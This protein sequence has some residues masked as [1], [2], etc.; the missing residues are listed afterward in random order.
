MS[1]CCGPMGTDL[2]LSPPFSHT[3]T[4][5]HTYTEVSM[6]PLLKQPGEEETML[7]CQSLSMDSCSDFPTTLAAV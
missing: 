7:N 2:Y 3:H 5:T 1:V 6:D 4:H